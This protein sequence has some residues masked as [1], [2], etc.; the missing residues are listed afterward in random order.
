[1]NHRKRAP[2]IILDLD[3]T[4]YRGDTLIP[5]AREAVERLHRRA[6]PIVFLTNAIESRAEHADKLIGLDIPA[7]PDEIVNASLIL[8]HYLSHEVPDATVF[9]ISD[10]PLLEALS[11]NF[12]LSEDPQEIDVVVASCDRTFDYRKLNIAFK[13][14]QRGARFLAT[15]ADAT[16]PV[17][18]GE[19]LP[20]A[21]AVI[22]AL[23]GCS[24]RKLEMVVGKPSPLAAEVAVERLGR[25]ASEC[26]MVGDN[27][28]SDVLMGHS[29]GMITVLVLSGVTRRADLAHARVQPDYVLE[30]IADLPCLLDGE[31]PPPLADA[32][33]AHDEPVGEL[34]PG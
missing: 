13:A 14:L 26:V 3:G 2:G 12:R 11:A 28:E 10:P 34:P 5:G 29:A 18:G 21:G 30:S 20:D 16:A 23:E 33:P 4:I 9:A 31:C 27:L 32:P 6:H 24:G 7:S 15:N 19:L 8:T 1:M 17:A 22:G 25:P